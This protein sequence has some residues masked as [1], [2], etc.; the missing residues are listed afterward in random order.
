[1]NH[2]ESVEQAK[3]AKQRAATDVSI[4]RL[5]AC[6]VWEKPGAEEVRNPKSR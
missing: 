4:D 6:F 1:M 2:E 5:A 3:L